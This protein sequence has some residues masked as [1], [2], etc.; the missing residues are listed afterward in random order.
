MKSGEKHESTLSREDQ[1]FISRW[2]E[3]IGQSNTD[4]ADHFV[5]S[6][7]EMFSSLDQT[8]VEAW[9]MSA[10]QAFDDGEPEKAADVLTRP[11]DFVNDYLFQHSRCTLDSVS[12]FL[13]HF[14]IGL[15]GRELTI[16]KH[17]E[18][19]TDT[20][21]IFL[22]D[23][24]KDYFDRELNFA[25]YKLTAVHL[26][27]QTRYGTWRHQ[28]VETLGRAGDTAAVLAVF[29]RL[30]CVRLDAC[31]A[32]ELPGLYRQ[33]EA[34]AYYSDEHKNEW[35][36]FQSQV[37][38]L[39]ESTATTLDSVAM[40]EQ[41]LGEQLPALKRY[42]SD[43][44]LAGVRK[45]MSARIEREKSA[46][47][48]ALGELQRS[49]RQI[50]SDDDQTS[51][52]DDEG[53]FTLAKGDDQGKAYRVNME[54]RYDDE[55]AQLT[56]EIETLMESILQDFGEIP[57]H[58]M[59]GI[60]SIPYA[61]D[62]EADLGDHGIDADVNGSL[63]NAIRYREWDYLRQRYREG[64]CLMN[65]Y[66]VPPVDDDFVET[67]LAKYRGLLK[68]IKKTFEA[69][70]GESKL[71]RKQSHG[72]DIDL[73][74]LIEAQADFASGLEMSDKVY[75]CY[76]NRERSIA[77]M[78]MVDMSGSTHGWIND[79]ERESL[80]LLCEALETLGDLYAIYG[81]SG[82]TNKRCE[83]FRV[84]R[85][86]EPYSAIVRQRI[87][88]IRSKGFTRMGAAIRHLGHQLNMTRARTKLLITLSDGRPEDYDAYRG[89][90][91]VEDTRHALQEL[92]HDG[93]HSFCVTIDK[94]AQDYLPHMY[95]ATNYAVIHEVKQLPLKVAD[96][97]HRLTAL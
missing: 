79:A 16:T 26:W 3:I 31:I 63:V 91:A 5:N 13:Q 45:V 1:D 7:P 40:I 82:K 88:G 51:T 74:A 84:K 59:D 78:F 70:L 94:E 12:Q 56:P 66:D 4:L 75:T 43:M 58:Y 21:K 18:A 64:Y 86:D 29:N 71:L 96:I 41:Y 67:T 72:D 83:T 69:V 2:T 38:L 36:M 19:Y 50:T 37:P 8:G 39:T 85:F 93:I 61:S 77:V 55:L 53:R 32:R 65:E 60:T 92:R 62:T 95:G 24:I 17:H 80:I 35:Q 11:A 42:Q 23:H 68:S 14:V 87:S 49:I 44:L 46:V 20:E 30:E 54:L 6:A 33:F 76:R 34:V 73:D 89:R 15:G 25:V 28:V 97:Y 52:D 48:A 10:L 27:A 22:P 47:Q 90:Y 81:F 57:E 9:L